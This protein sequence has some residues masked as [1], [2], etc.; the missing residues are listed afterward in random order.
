MKQS[1]HTLRQPV[2]PC[3]KVSLKHF[4]DHS[5]RHDKKQDGMYRVCPGEKELF[6]DGERVKRAP[7]IAWQ[8][9]T[10]VESKKRVTIFRRLGIKLVV[11]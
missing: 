9:N 11:P 5:G 6:K 4:V 7:L 1:T 8:P 3:Q 2:V 10:H